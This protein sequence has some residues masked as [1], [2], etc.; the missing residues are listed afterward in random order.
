MGP[1]IYKGGNDLSIEHS[2]GKYPTFS[3]G[4]TFNGALCRNTHIVSPNATLRVALH[5][6]EHTTVT[7]SHSNYNGNTI[8]KSF[9]RDFP[10]IDSGE[11]CVTVLRRAPIHVAP[12]EPVSWP[13]TI[14]IPTNVSNHEP[15]PLADDE[16]TFLPI[17]SASVATHRLP[18]IFCTNGGGGYVEYYFKATLLTWSGGWKT[19]AEA[20]FPIII[21]D[22]PM[23]PPIINFE[24]TRHCKK[25]KVASYRLVP[26][27]EDASLS[28]TQRTRQIFASSK[29]PQIGGNLEID[30]PTVVQLDNPTSVPIMMRFVPE[31]ATTSDGI[32]GVPVRIELIGLDVTITSHTDMPYSTHDKLAH[33]EHSTR[34]QVWPP[35][36]SAQAAGVDVSPVYIPC[37]GELPAMDV[38]ERCKLKFQ[39]LQRVVEVA[40]KPA[41]R[42]DLESYNMAHSHKMGFEITVRI[43][44]DKIKMSF[45]ERVKVLAASDEGTGSGTALGDDGGSAGSSHEA[46]D[47]PAVPVIVEPSPSE[48]WIQPPRGDPPPSFSEVQR[49]DRSRSRDER[50]VVTA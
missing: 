37:G 1:K 4:D 7:S 35:S 36:K 46:G 40:R 28:F 45:V 39:R 47:A 24:F 27:M 42:P 6:R 34:L 49:E 3:P 26:G 38:G 9:I 43:A 8:S 17:D 50:A 44:S 25:A 21:L 19:E 18:S 30:L 22:R 29:M 15:F 2:R 33:D 13:F 11:I 31:A 32:R 5:G 14:E 12:G 41:L 23:T 20:V 10:L 16:K 48:S